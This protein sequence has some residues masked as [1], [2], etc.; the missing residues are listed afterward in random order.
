MAFGL[1]DLAIDVSSACGFIKVDSNLVNSASN[2]TT[3]PP[4]TTPVP[5]TTPAP[6]TTS[7][8][9]GTTVPSWRQNSTTAPSNQ[10]TPAETTPPTA[11]TTP[12]VNTYGDYTVSPS[13]LQIY[14]MYND[15]TG[16]SNTSSTNTYAKIDIS[17]GYLF[18]TAK[19]SSL[20]DRDIAKLW[21]EN[22]SIVI[23]DAIYNGVNYFVVQSGSNSPKCQPGLS[24]YFLALVQQNKHSSSNLTAIKNAYYAIIKPR[25]LVNTLSNIYWK[26]VQALTNNDKG[27]YNSILF[28]INTFGSTA[29][30]NTLSTDLSA[31]NVQNII[32]SSS[33]STPFTVDSIWCYQ[34]I[35]IAFELYRY[36]SY[37]KQ[38]GAN[39]TGSGK[40]A[41]TSTVNSFLGGYKTYLGKINQVAPKSPLLFLLQNPPND[42]NCAVI[43]TLQKYMN[44]IRF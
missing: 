43:S 15:A 16:Y 27:T 23:D 26:N 20:T 24:S 31:N 28:V 39:T 13:S 17:Y 5:T 19:V 12:S 29:T 3:A 44:D 42:T 40:P 32:S 22:E 38:N 25:F 18:D 14:T 21:N 10:T 33:N 8:P 41:I 7:V 11:T 2:K 34:S 36:I 9:T 37:F 1:G 30:T 35:S 6:T 4:T